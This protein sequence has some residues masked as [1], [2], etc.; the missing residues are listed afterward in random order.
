MVCGD[1]LFRAHVTIHCKYTL[2]IVS[3]VC[4][5]CVKICV[6]DDDKAVYGCLVVMLA[7]E[8]HMDM[9]CWTSSGNAL[10]SFNVLHDNTINK[11]TLAYSASLN[12]H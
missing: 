1:L 5:K 3:L 6:D 9:I 4:K 12:T 8:H 2:S 10:H 7:R 11:H